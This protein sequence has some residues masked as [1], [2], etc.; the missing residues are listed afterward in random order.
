MSASDDTR[1][2]RGETLRFT[3]PVI[4]ENTLTIFIGLI[5]SRIISTISS[6]AL[7][8]IGSANIVQT[9][10]NAVFGILTGST[11]VLVAQQI[12]A[13]QNKDAADTIEQAI[14]FGLVTTLLFM[15]LTLT[16]ATPILSLTMPN[17]EEKLLYEAVRYFR[18][19]ML[20]LPTLIL[21]GLLS[22]AVRSMGN[23]RSPMIVTMV[24]NLF[25]V[26]FGFLFIKVMKLE[27][28][29]AG[30]AYVCCRLIGFILMFTI[31]MRDRRFFTLKIR[32]MFKPHFSTIKRLLKIGVPCG[33][34]SIFCQLGYLLANSMSIALGTQ[35]ASVYQI[36]N[37]I[38]SFVGLP[39]NIVSP[40]GLSIVGRLVGAGKI[41]ESKKEG[42]KLILISV[43]ITV[44]LALL[45]IV[46]AKPLCSIY[47]SDEDTIN[48]TAS[49]VW[50]LLIYDFLGCIINSND[51]QLRAAG[52]VKFV[53]FTTLSFVWLVRLPLTWLF[54]FKLHWGVMGI[55]MA[56]SINLFF[57][58]AIGVTRHYCSDK[59][60]RNKV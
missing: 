59:W 43:S 8:A 7:A 54:C 35:E 11:P 39:Q 52:D 36:L 16:L 50:V 28:I 38:A 21:H 60:Y 10:I 4:I 37:T 34:E 5:F 33:L 49:I 3:I 45:C 18:V 13:K 15:V 23:S 42:L 6:S 55:F 17:A 20:S 1:S 51:P 48:A 22:S 14:L 57:R 58:A 47:S 27:E 2:L 53:M 25:Q 31:L 30:L 56:N 26:A 46:F 40:V 9:F 41:K 24:M 29:G 32:N 44:V 12:G 19:L